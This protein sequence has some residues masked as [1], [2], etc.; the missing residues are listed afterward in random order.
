MFSLCPAS[1]RDPWFNLML[2]GSS[3]SFGS[4]CCSLLITER[5]RLHIKASRLIIHAKTIY[6]THFVYSYIGLGDLVSY[7]N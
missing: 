5:S 6:S 3:P 1:P 2:L 7:Q 4:L